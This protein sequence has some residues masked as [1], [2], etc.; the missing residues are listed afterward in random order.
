M[1]LLGVKGKTMYTTEIKKKWDKYFHFKGHWLLIHVIES[2]C[3]H[4][5]ERIDLLI[6]CFYKRL[7]I[8][9]PY[10]AQ[11]YEEIEIHEN[12]INGCNIRNI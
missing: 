5:Y 10:F 7:C 1:L 2:F 9:K 8:F 6:M 11:K 4:E 3:K 12:G